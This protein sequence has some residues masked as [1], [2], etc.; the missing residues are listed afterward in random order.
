MALTK[1]RGLGL[2]TLDDNIT[3][4]TAGKGVHFGVTSATASNLLDDY[5]EGTWTPT[6]KIN[7][8]TSGIAYSSRSGAYVKIGELVYVEADITLSSK[9][10]ST[11]TVR[12][13]SLP[14]TVDDRTAQTS[15]DGGASFI[16]FS[17]GTTGIYTPIG[18]IG[19]G[20]TT[21]LGMYVATSSGGTVGTVLQN[22]KITDSLSIRIGHVYRQA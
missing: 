6:I 21:D 22:T 5:E 18:V 20:G 10:S 3:F 8:S 13:G 2:G 14:F 15:I 7:D 11:G 12:V 17:V 9:G 19:R 1:V 4:S 16:P